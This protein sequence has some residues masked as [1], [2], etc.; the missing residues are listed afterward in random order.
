MPYD[1]VFDSPMRTRN[2]ISWEKLHENRLDYSEFSARA[3]SINDY[4]GDGIGVV[5]SVANLRQHNIYAT[6]PER[7]PPPHDDRFDFPG[8]YIF[9]NHAGEPF[10]VGISRT[11]VQRIQQHIKGT[12]HNT[13]TVA[14]QIFAEEQNPDNREE[15]DNHADRGTITG[16]LMQQK[17]AMYK[18]T[19]D[20]QMHFDEF[21]IAQELKTYYNSFR[22][23]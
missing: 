6:Y 13:A 22:T 23:H 9:L 11:V 17:V 15:F 19:G 8:L 12:A 16:L 4:F 5:T 3:I 14:Y 10:Y 1:H 21:R 7:L 2:T 20:E 18:I